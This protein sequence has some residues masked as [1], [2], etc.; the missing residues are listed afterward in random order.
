MSN[1]DRL[2]ERLARLFG[3]PDE[4]KTV[5]ETQRWLHHRGFS[6]CTED[7]AKHL[8]FVRRLVRDGRVTDD[9]R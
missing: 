7:N 8:L 4:P 2:D 1:L 6:E 9:G 3:R 5:P